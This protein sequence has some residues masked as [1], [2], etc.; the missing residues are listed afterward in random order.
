MNGT[1]NDAIK[2]GYSDIALLNGV[3]KHG[4]ALRN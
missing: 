2:M 4:G 3:M 1:K